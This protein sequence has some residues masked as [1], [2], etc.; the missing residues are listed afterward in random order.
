MFGITVSRFRDGMELVYSD[1]RKITDRT[2]WGL[3]VK[4]FRGGAK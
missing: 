1:G 3:L 4:M 2:P